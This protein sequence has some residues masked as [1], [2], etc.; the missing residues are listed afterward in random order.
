MLDRYS[1]GTKLLITPLVVAVLLVIVA[2]AAYLGMQAQQSALKTIY[3]VRLLRLLETTEGLNRVRSLNEEVAL[4]LLD[5]RAAEGGA[6]AARMLDEQAQTILHELGERVVAFET[7]SRNDALTAEESAAYAEVIETLSAYRGELS[8]MVASI[9]PARGLDET[10]SSMLWSWFSGFIAA[11]TKLGDIQKRLG[12][13]KY[14]EAREFG[15]TAT[16]LLAAVAMLA[17]GVASSSGLLIRKSIVAA[18]NRIRDTAQQ[19]KAGDLTCRAAISGHDEVAQ[20]A[21]AFNQVADTFQRLVQNVQRGAETLGQAAQRLLRDTRQAER[22]A[23]DQSRVTGSVAATMEEMSASIVDLAQGAERLRQSSARTLSEAR[24]GSGA[25]ASMRAQADSVSVAFDDIRSSVED[26]VARSAAISDLTTQLKE[27][28]GQTNLLALNAAI[29]A[30]R[31]GEHGRGFA[32][33][34]DEVRKLAEQ[35]NRAAGDI[36]SLAA[37]LGSRSTAVGLSLDS[38]HGSLSALL[39]QLT[40]L[41]TIVRSSVEAVEASTREFERVAEVVSEQSRG[42]V[43]IAGNVDT[44]ARMADDNRRAVVAAANSAGELEG[45][46]S[47]LAGS[48]ASLRV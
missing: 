7:A 35:S 4:T 9:D 43:K 44:I 5:Q 24:Q 16:A 20:S 15:E 29:E 1:I 32:V 11:A 18:V 28:A 13:E 6:D 42:G 41:E 38:G 2:A 3:E 17:L 39:V 36:E 27:V 14:D 12:R 33:V 46:A 34:A 21:A 47:T 8:Q 25:L 37:M 22:S 30:A 31:A 19:L 45:L 10:R 40:T 26:F 48:I 23:E